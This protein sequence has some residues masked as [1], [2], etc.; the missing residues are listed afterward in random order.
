MPVGIT[1]DKSWE[2]ER[3][4]NPTGRHQT[5][6]NSRRPENNILRERKLLQN[7]KRGESV[8][9]REQNNF[10]SSR[11]IEAQV[12][13]MQQVD[14]LEIFLDSSHLETFLSAQTKQPQPWKD[15]LYKLRW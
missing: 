11:R 10:S 8:L 3:P 5:T 4:H 12:D 14:G 9:L 15:F 7:R 1:L 2:C 6:Y 13:E